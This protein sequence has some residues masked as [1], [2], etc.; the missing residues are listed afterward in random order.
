VAAEC[1]IDHHIR[2]KGRTGGEPGSPNERA[3]ADLA[4]QQHGVVSRRQLLALGFGRRAIDRRIGSGRLHPVHRGVYAAGHPGLSAHGRWLA[5]VLAFGPGATLSHRSA[6]ALWGFLRVAA[7]PVD[8]TIAE[9][10]GR[11]RPGI[12]LHRVRELHA[13]DR[14]CHDS[15]P[16]T[17][18]ART[19]LDLA[20][21]LHPRR[22]ER[23]F[24]EAER[25][26][27]LDL[28][29]LR[30]LFKTKPGRARSAVTGGAAVRRT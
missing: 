5:A 24:E 16:V 22:L 20:E 21:E 25:L 18:V 10:R 11:G 3:I 12:R 6:A 26:S 27:L 4:A 28:T 30:E 23:A 1:D 8:V 13:D 19:L 2:G 7:A 29:A 17:A 14:T 15:I 9:A